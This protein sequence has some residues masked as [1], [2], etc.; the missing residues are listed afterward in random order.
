M[1][2]IIERAKWNIRWNIDKFRDPNDTISTALKNGA[3]LKSFVEGP[4]YLGRDVI[5]GNLLLNSG[6]DELWDIVTG[7]S[8]NV[9]DSTYA[10]IGVGDDGTTAASASQTDLQGASTDYNAMDSSY[11]TSTTQAVNFR[12]TYGSAEANFHW[13]EFVVKQSTSSICL[14]RKVSD[15]GTKASGES[16]TITVT[17]T[18]S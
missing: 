10:Q 17:I 5:E 18:L 6:I 9:F 1:S 3:D 8:A 12:A 11:P 14:N 15:K 16:W 7:A 4:D 13:N 2:S